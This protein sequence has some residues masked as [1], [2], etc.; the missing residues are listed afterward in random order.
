[1]HLHLAWAQFWIRLL[2]IQPFLTMLRVV[3]TV[4]TLVATTTAY[5]IS[6]QNLSVV[7]DDTFPRPLSY[8][9]APTGETVSAALTG[10]GFHLSL[11]LNAGQATCGESGI[12]TDYTPVRFCG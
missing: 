6:S 7:L 5:V 11:S 1:M 8:S 4:W 9:F 2:Q 3:A 10:W 12:S